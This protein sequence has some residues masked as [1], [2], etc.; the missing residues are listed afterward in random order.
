MC[1]KILSFYCYHGETKLFLITEIDCGNVY[2]RYANIT[3][4][5]PS[6]NYKSEVAFT[7]VDGYY[8]PSGETTGTAICTVNATWQLDPCTG[9]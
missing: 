8:L 2:I 1:N 7:C 5:S 6:T 9:R 4:R 3:Q